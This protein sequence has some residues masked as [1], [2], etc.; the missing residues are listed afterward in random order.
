MVLA[1]IPGCATQRT[2]VIDSRSDI[3]QLGPDVWGHVYTKVGGVW[4]LSSDKV[5]L[6]GGWYAGPFREK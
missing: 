4:Q 6:P 3:V 2:V 5:H 1:L